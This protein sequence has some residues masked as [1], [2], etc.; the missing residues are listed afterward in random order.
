MQPG[1]GLHNSAI[2][3][4]MLCIFDSLPLSVWGWGVL[5]VGIISLSGI[6]GGLL[7]PVLNSRYYSTVMR[8]L[9]GL[10]AGSLTAT[11]IFQLIPEVRHKQTLSLTPLFGHNVVAAKALFAPLAARFVARGL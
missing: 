5:S 8:F 10:A 11:S 1:S 6:F 4:L 9:I 3:V 7:W 2:N